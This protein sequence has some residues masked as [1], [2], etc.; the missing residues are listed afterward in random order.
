MGAMIG[1]SVML[2]ALA[3]LCTMPSAP[4]GAGYWT[5]GYAL[6]F[7]RLCLYLAS[8]QLH[9]EFSVF[10]A[11]SLQGISSLFLLAG[12][13]RFLGSDH[14]RILLS[15]AASAVCLWAAFSTFIVDDFPLRTIPLYLVSG[16]ALI[17][18][19][20]ALLRARRDTVITAGRF[21]GLMLLLWGL[22]KIEYPWL[23][24]VEWLA[25]FGFLLSQFIAMTVAVGLLLALAGRLHS[26]AATLERKHEQSREHLKTLNQLLEISLG[27]NALEC[28][29]TEALDA[30]LAAPWLAVEP[31]GGIFLVEDGMLRLTAQRN[32][33]QPLHQMCAKVAFGE[34]LCGRAAQQKRIIH[35]AHVDERHEI[36]FPGMAPHGHYAVPLVI[37]GQSLGVLILSLPDGRQRDEA[38]MEHLNAVADA[39]AGMIMRKRAEQAAE[40]SHSRLIEAQRIAEVGSWDIDLKTLSGVWS[41]EE[42][43]ILGYRPGEVAPTRQSFLARVHPDD[44]D[45]VQEV[46]QSADWQDSFVFKHRVVHPDGTVLYV[47]EAAEV[48]RDEAG[49]P[50]HIVGTTQDVTE[51]KAAKLALIKAKQDAEAANRAKSSFLATMSHELRTPLN[52]VIGFAQLLESLGPPGDEDEA[53]RGGSVPGG[54]AKYREYVG[55]I[56]E[57]GEHLLSV[58]NDILDL[59]RIEAGQSVLSEGV[60]D[61]VD[62]VRRTAALMQA[63]A[64]SGDLALELSL[65]PQALHLEGDERAVKQI[66]LNLVANA[67]KFT[68]AGGRVTVVLQKVEDSLEMVVEDTGIGIA[69]E[70]HEQVFEP[71]FQV[72]SELG[73]RFEGTGLGLPL[74]RSLVEMHN[75]RI[76]L[77]SV[78]GEGTRIVVAFPPDRLVEPGAGNKAPGALR[79]GGSDA[80]AE[81]ARKSAT[82]AAAD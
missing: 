19:G 56:R 11:E 38:E 45:D 17:A 44:L 1:A 43:R 41:D 74:V 29:L 82:A 42:Y 26:I 6:W 28:Q 75:G 69:P 55:H 54:P 21:V 8:G 61:I 65:P 70:D 49:R 31:E 47:S 72:E 35:A 7:L 25:P 58:I 66:L 36:S 24:P 34:C 60:F 16:G 12:T 50:R 15:L 59:S 20:I 32:L 78:P 9:P 67:L 48:V 22:H 46:L 79:T 71:F 40:D 2:M 57:S 64:R 37:G 76:A 80:P 13:F 4:A 23:R 77:H 62:L 73:R 30:I 51:E 33:P 63:K 27:S 14:P 81:Q 3:Y 68:E 10:L 39:L 52:A 5:V 18:A 53:S